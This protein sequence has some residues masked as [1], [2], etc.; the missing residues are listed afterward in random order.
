[1][2][3]ASFDLNVYLQNNDQMR[4]L[5]ALLEDSRRQEAALREKCRLLESQLGQ[6]HHVNLELIDCLK[7]NG[8]KF[9]R[10]ADMR[11]WEL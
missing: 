4:M 8:Y 6:A 11:T 2:S 7:L 10:T 5:E 1:M 9:R 3:R